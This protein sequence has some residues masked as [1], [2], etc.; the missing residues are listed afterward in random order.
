M[1]RMLLNRVP[2]RAPID[3]SEVLDGGFVIKKVEGQ[4]VIFSLYEAGYV[5]W[6]NFEAEAH[7]FVGV[8]NKLCPQSAPSQREPEEADRAP[9]ESLDS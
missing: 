6:F 1:S 2:R 4:N 8:V 9:A 3:F 7:Q 5:L